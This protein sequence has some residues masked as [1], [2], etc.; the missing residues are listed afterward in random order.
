MLINLT[1]KIN[2]ILSKFFEDIPVIS[3][4]ITD[5]ITPCFKTDIIDYSM[6]LRT[7]N[8]VEYKI[9]FN[10]NYYPK[11]PISKK[12]ML[13]IQERLLNVFVFDI[14]YYKVEDVEVVDHNDFITCNV[15][16]TVI[17]VMSEKS[18]GMEDIEYEEI[19]NIEI[20]R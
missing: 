18:R 16:Y 3:S 6:K 14:D 15:D 11:L 5:N 4:E 10:I 19:D 7:N 1:K 2:T 8:V 13:G 9:S 12:I 17:K 20:K